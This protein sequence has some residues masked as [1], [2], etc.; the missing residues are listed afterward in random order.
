MCEATATNH[1]DNLETSAKDNQINQIKTNSEK[2]SDKSQL[3]KKSN[4]W[5]LNVG[6]S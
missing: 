2:S 3:S 5:R 6:G 1:K 4:D